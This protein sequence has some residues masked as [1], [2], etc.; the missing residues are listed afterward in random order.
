MEN[1]IYFGK[2]G[3]FDWPVSRD[4]GRVEKRACT[5]LEALILNLKLP[6]L[7]PKKLTKNWFWKPKTDLKIWVILKPHLA[8]KNPVKNET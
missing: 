7:N 3:N 5:H 8:P 2:M 6:T 1:T 4:L